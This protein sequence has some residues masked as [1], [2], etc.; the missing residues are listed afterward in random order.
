MFIFN[1]LN[2]W[3]RAGWIGHWEINKH[4]L[5]TFFYIILSLVFVN[6][7]WWLDLLGI[8]LQNFSIVNIKNVIIRL[9]FYGRYIILFI[10]FRACHSVY[11]I[12]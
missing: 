6:F 10:K 4:P 9:L 11:I 5:N 8:D 12:A 2:K 1:L 7:L 3:A